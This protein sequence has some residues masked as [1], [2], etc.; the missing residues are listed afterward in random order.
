MAEELILW[1]TFEFNYIELGDDFLSGSSISSVKKNPDLLELIWGKTGRVYG[2]LM[3]RLSTMKAIS[4][5][6]NKDS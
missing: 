5:A 6:Y 4:L 1:C 2:L 3:G